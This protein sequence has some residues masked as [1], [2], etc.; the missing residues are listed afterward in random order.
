MIS[1]M[2][3]NNSFGII[4]D[5]QDPPLLLCISAQ[6]R[7]PPRAVCSAPFCLHCTPMTALP[8]IYHSVVKYVDNTTIIHYITNNDEQSYQEEM[9]NHAEW[10]SADN[11]LL[12]VSNAKELILKKRRR[13]NTPLSASVELRWSR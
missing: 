1:R 4:S 2:L 8:D 3:R 6:R 5:I 10:C 9:N 12:N 13:R 11:L 7:S